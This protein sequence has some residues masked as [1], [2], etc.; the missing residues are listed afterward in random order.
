MANIMQM[1][2]KAQQMKTKM[3]DM[4]E[5]AGQI[6]MIGE[7]GA[8]AVSCHMNGK[9]DVTKLTISPQ[10]VA[11][12]DVE[13]LEDLILAALRDARAK[14]EAHMAAETEKIMRDLGLPP[15]M[16]LPF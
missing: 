4:Q 9:F 5:R 6:E 16:G 12:G 11:A 3:Q 13:M 10:T 14:A 2:A 1:M 15:G 8:G 7:A